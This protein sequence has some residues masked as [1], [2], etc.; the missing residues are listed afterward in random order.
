MAVVSKLTGRH[1]REI[2][3]ARVQVRLMN[4]TTFQFLHYCK[5]RTFYIIQ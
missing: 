4:L 5:K 2:G 3:D 1:A